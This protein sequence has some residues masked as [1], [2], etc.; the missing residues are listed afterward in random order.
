MT[1][2]EEVA[3]ALYRHAA[4]KLGP[5]ECGEESGWRMYLGEARI[6]VE[7]IREPTEAMMKL[8]I[9]GPIAGAAE[10]E[11]EYTVS[12]I[13]MA[14]IDAILNES[15]EPACETHPPGFWGG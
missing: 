13:F 5:R 8:G 11:T 6:A 3:R 9:L 14:M 15:P 2:L 10:D 7:A 12:A 1:K 4:P